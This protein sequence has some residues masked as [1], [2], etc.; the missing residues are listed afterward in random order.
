MGVV[1]HAN[2]L[3]WCDLARTEHL[4][5]AG[6]AYRAL[7]EQ[8]TFL[9]VTEAAVTYRRPVRFDDDLV[10]RCWVRDVASRQVSFGYAIVRQD[11][12]QLVATARTTLM[13]LG[14]QRA[15]VRLGEEITRALV[16]V[17]DPVRL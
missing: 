8:G 15:P 6:I 1:Y 4:R 13:A 16:P 12:G 7:E 5:R 17:A 11:D 2:Y 9:A 3:I 10:V 14:A